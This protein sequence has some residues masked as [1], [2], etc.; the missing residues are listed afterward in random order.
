M[1]I[2]YKIAYVLLVVYN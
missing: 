1:G 2:I